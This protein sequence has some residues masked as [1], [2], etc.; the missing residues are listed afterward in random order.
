[1]IAFGDWIAIGSQCEAGIALPL[2]DYIMDYCNAKRKTNQK[3][4]T[5]D[6]HVR[7]NAVYVDTLGLLCA[8]LALAKDACGWLSESQ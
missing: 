3:R 6:L 1:M 4:L 5:I 2:F 8:F 7:Q